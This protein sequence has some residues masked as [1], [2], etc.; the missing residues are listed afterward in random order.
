MSGPFKPSRLPTARSLTLAPL[1]SMFTGNEPARPGTIVNHVTVPF[2]RPRGLELKTSPEF[3]KMH[4]D[5]LGLL[6]AAPGHG[7]VKTTV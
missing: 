1:N 7:L 5:V 4:D 6:R 2:P 3:G